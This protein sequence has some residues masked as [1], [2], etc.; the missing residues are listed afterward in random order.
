MG[1]DD[2][3][4]QHRKE[5][6]D[7]LTR[8]DTRSK[9]EQDKVIAVQ[10]KAELNRMNGKRAGYGLPPVK[11]KAK[12][13]DQHITDTIKMYEPEPSIQQQVINYSPK[14]DPGNIMYD[15][16]SNSFK[17]EKEIGDKAMETYVKNNNANN[18]NPGTFKKL[19]EKDERDF[20][21]KRGK[22]FINKTLTPVENPNNPRAVSFNPTTQLFTNEKRDIAF[23]TYDEADTWNRAIGVNNTKYYQD[24]ASPEQVGALAY[25]LEKSRQM[26]G[27]DGRYDKPKLKPFIKK[28]K[29]KP[30]KIEPVPINYESFRPVEIP[31]RTPQ[32][33]EMER[34]FKKMMDDT[35]REKEKRENSGLA[36]L[37]GGV[38]LI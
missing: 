8:P 23:K 34:R 25:R 24:K 6:T 1:Y 4:P 33:L 32:D 14:K 19:V 28:T 11:A 37:M 31:R 22:R 15:P 9:E 17:T 30:Y 35:Q 36:G 3:N 27:G 10:E 21:D 29:L 20:N 2:N 16:P 13:M 12:S 18:E 38:K 26:N 7:Y 5:L